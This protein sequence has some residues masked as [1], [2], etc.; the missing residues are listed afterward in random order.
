MEK[1]YLRYKI[2]NAQPNYVPGMNIS[3][4]LWVENQEA[5]DKKLKKLMARVIEY[6]EVYESRKIRLNK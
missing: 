5:K 2:E 4:R 1:I 6:Y 3:G